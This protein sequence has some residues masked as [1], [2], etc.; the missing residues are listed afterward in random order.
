[1]GTLGSYNPVDN[2]NP[3]AA[4]EEN[5]GWADSQQ[6]LELGGNFQRLEVL[7]AS[8]KKYQHD[9]S[10]DSAELS[11]H[12]AVLKR[13]RAWH[14]WD[15]ARRESLLSFVLSKLK[16]RRRPA[17]PHEQELLSLALYYF[18]PRAEL[19]ATICDFG[20]GRFERFEQNLGKIDNLWREKPGWV[21]LH[22]EVLNFRH[23]QYIEDQMDVFNILRF[24]PDLDHKLS[25]QNW[26][27]GAWNTPISTDV[28]IRSNEYGAKMNFWDLVRSDLPSQL[29]EGRED[30]LNFTTTSQPAILD[31]Q[32]LSQHRAYTGAVLVRDL[33]RT[34]RR[35]DGKSQKRT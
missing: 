25:G 16:I 12:R 22:F 31:A 9:Q 32:M 28:A 13:L 27:P 1:M 6:N 8:T 24:I 3:A 20:N 30:D 26:S 15:Q 5:S 7:P 33:F 34:F 17:C 35:S 21:T 10:S 4:D 18:P 23:R 14:D 2:I 11:K 29:T 19:R